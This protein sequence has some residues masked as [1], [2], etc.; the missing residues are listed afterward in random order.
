MFNMD[1]RLPGSSIHGVSPGKN[2]GVSCHAL[3]QAPPQQGS[4][5]GLLHCRWTLYCLSH[6]GN[7]RILEWV[8]HP[9]SRGSSWSR[10]QT[11]VSCTAGKFFAELPGKPKDGRVPKLETNCFCLCSQL[12][13]T[14]CEPM[15]YSLPG[16]SVHGIFQARILEW[17]AISSYRRSSQPRDWSCISWVSCIGRQ[18]LYHWATREA[19][20]P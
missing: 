16:S 13:P 5:S 1:C 9:F 4:N 20:C 15:D 6:Q 3:L 11:R 7:S 2:T 10:N 17:V 14:L 18:T 8:A 19:H 12:C